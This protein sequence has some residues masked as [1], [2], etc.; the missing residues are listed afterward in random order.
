VQYLAGAQFM[1]F[2]EKRASMGA[3]HGPMPGSGDS[4][5]AAQAITKDLGDFSVNIAGR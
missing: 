1:I 4:T 5:A 2:L 3:G